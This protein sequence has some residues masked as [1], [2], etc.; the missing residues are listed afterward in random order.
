[1]VREYALAPATMSFSE[2][3]SRHGVSFHFRLS[4]KYVNCGSFVLLTSVVENKQR[5]QYEA[6]TATFLEIFISNALTTDGELVTAMR[7]IYDAQGYR[8]SINIYSSDYTDLRAEKLGIGRHGVVVDLP[9]A[10]VQSI[11]ERLEEGA[12]L[13]EPV[14]KQKAS[15]ASTSGTPPPRALSSRTVSTW[16]HK[17]AYAYISLQHHG[18][19]NASLQDRGQQ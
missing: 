7:L 10:L 2:G 13:A 12:H 9:S 1:M 3:A 16:G 11:G 14:H 4:H 6:T 19:T 18:G 15:E 8:Y 5:N 17:S